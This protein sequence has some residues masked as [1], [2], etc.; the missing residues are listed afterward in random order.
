MIGTRPQ[1]IR[2]NAINPATVVTNFFTSAGMSHDQAQAY[3]NKS[4]QD[5]PH[6][7]RGNAVRH[8]GALLLPHR[9]QQGWLDH[10]AGESLLN[11]DSL[12]LTES[13]W[14]RMLPL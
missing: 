12:S 5:A 11:K 6:R 10:R 1:G 3:M 13:T 9:Q 8:C 14:R 7:P 2:V 4:G